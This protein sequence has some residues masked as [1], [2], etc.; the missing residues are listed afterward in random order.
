MKRTPAVAGQFYYADPEKLTKQVEGFV[1]EDALKEHAKGILV[2]HAGLIYSGAVA[3]GV[4]SSIVLPKTIVL[5]GPNHTGLGSRA[6]IMH[7]GQ[8]E[9]P[10][11]TFQIDSVLASKIV[12]ETGIVKDAQAHLFE[13]SLEVQLPFIGY[14]K[15]D[16]SIVPITVLSL[17][18]EELKAA[19]EGIA[20]A[21]KDVKYE[22][23]I[24]ASSDMSHYVPDTEARQKDRLAIDR[25]LALDPAGLYEIVRKEKISMCGCLPAVIMLYASLALGARQARLV[26]YS[27]SGEVSRDYDQVVGYAGIIVK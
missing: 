21:I 7:E 14:F 11:G 9:M 12:R 17:S 1:D 10:T 13:H 23:L 15:K 6:S 20:R 18:L 25:V 5:I 19:G 8:W 24:A 4:Y 27:T 3:G 2:P 26:K 16:A 22:V